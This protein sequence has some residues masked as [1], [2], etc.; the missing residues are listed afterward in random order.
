M[1]EVWV[2]AEPI[3]KRLKKT[4]QEGSSGAA[5]EDEDE[6]ISVLYSKSVSVSKVKTVKSDNKD[7]DIGIDVI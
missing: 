6:N 5:E 3:I 1:K 2:K 4:E 7:D